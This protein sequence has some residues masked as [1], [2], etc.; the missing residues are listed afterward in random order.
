MV[1]LGSPQRLRT[2]YQ[3]NLQSAYMAA[4]ALAQEQASRHAFPYRMY[5]AVM[6]GRTRPSHAR[7]N[8]RV[9]PIDSPVWSVIAPPNGFNCRCAV[10][11]LSAADLDRLKLK[12]ETDA[13]IVTRPVPA[14]PLTNKRTGEVDPAKLI[15]RG[16]SIPD[17]AWPGRRMTLWADS[18]WDYNP[19]VSVLDK[20]RDI[21]IKKTGEAAPDIA[22]AVVRELVGSPSF[23]HWF[24]RPVGE[25]PI[26]VLGAE[27]S[28][29]IGAR[30]QV[31]VFSPATH[32]K[33]AINHPEL[34]AADY[35]RVQDVI[36]Q[37]TAYQ[38]S[39]VSLVFVL[40]EAAGMTSVVKATQSG[41]G[42]FLT[43]LR[44]LPTDPVERAA[45]IRRIE[46]KAARYAGS[47]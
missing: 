3:T 14:G 7:L 44:H 24:E 20:V 12:V 34:V 5:V 29:M 15:Q 22:T 8:G 38:D 18:G 43:S 10:R 26:A 23:A 1:Q 27:H 32:A 46:R 6:D 30:G 33:Q 2:I 13:R 4:R 16:V 19:G 31:A 37:G 35:A 41:N 21:A 40:D 9:F 42:L 39:D 28:S 11:A 36:S 25:F 45:E 17:P 47:K